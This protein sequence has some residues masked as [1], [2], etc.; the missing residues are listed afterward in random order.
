MTPFSQ[1]TSL[2]LSEPTFP[3]KYSISLFDMKELE[4]KYYTREDLSDLSLF[5]SS[6]EQHLWNKFSYK[7]RRLQWL[8]GRIAAKH[9]VLDL[10]YP[11]Q[12]MAYARYNTLS[13][14]PE[15]SGRP[16]LSWT[17]DSTDP[18]P[19]ISLSHSGH[20]ATAIASFTKNCG[21]DIQKITSRI[22]KIREKFSEEDEEL[23]LQ[24]C[25]PSLTK[26]EQLIF[27]WSG[28]EAVKKGLL[29]KQ[30]T[31]FAGIHLLNL[32]VENLFIL[33]FSVPGSNNKVTV[34]ALQLSDFVIAFTLGNMQH[35]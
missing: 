35:A 9:A 28:K 12:E 33:Q 31:F 15:Q 20:Y 11:K 3:V 4:N 2:Y 27:L 22:H 5:L 26:T 21:I 17:N 7:K 25:A 32:T 14:L 6:E 8:G 16:V 13:I 19:G 18:L 1:G 29:H 24:E 34:Q 30:P 10:L 23:L